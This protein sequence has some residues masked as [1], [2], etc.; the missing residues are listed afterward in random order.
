M[1]DSLIPGYVAPSPMDP[2]RLPPKDGSI[3]LGATYGKRNWGAEL[4]ARY[5]F[6]GASLA[7]ADLKNPGES[8]PDY[9]DQYIPHSD[10]ETE[11]FTGGFQGWNIY[12]FW[13]V[14]ERMALY[15]FG[16]YYYRA[17]HYLDRSNASGTYWKS[18]MDNTYSDQ[19]AG[20]G[21]GVHYGVASWLVIGL[22]YG[23]INGAKLDIGWRF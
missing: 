14:S 15:G 4:G 16:G 3:W 13:D 11:E 8:A 22:G 9:T 17:H 1:P 23:S 20:G 12:L 2:G 21:A 18:H 6:I 7:F 5:K 19:A 10:Y